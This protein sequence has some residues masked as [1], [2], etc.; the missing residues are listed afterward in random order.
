[1]K[2]T[3]TELVLGFTGLLAS[4]KSTA[5]RFASRSIKCKSFA[6]GDEVRF[7]LRAKRKKV[8]RE[9]LQELSAAEKREFGAGVWAERLV[10]RIRKTKANVAVVEGFRNAAE[11]RVL[12]RAFKKKFVLIA[13]TAP[14]RVRYARAKRRMRESERVASLAAFE[15]SERIEAKSA[16]AGWG[17]AECI[18]RANYEIKNSGSESELRKSIAAAI[19]RLREARQ[20]S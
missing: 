7:A 15:R 11:I 6:L 14:L 8:T 13:V 17:I 20:H 10:A 5:A 19:K 18:A 9:A 1:M 12:K 2:K 3:K 16:S 4:G